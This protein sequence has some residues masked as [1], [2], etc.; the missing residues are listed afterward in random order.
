MYKTLLIGAKLKIYVY[1]R[2]TF[3]LKLFN[4]VALEIFKCRTLLQSW[5]AVYF[6]L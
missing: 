3:F 6:K 5:Y 4:N 2:E 1:V